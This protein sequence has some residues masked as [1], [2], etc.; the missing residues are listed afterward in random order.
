MQISQ[1]PISIFQKSGREITGLPIQVLPNTA[2]SA[3]KGKSSEAA[4]PSDKVTLSAGVPDR[5]TGVSASALRDKDYLMISAQIFNALPF[6]ERTQGLLETLYFY[7]SRLD[8]TDWDNFTTGVLNA[9]EDFDTF[10]LAA[11]RMFNSSGGSEKQLSEFL[12]F[13]AGLSQQNLDHFLHAADRN[14]G[15]IFDLMKNASVLARD[16]EGMSAYLKAARLSGNA[17]EK[18]NTVLGKF[19]EREQGTAGLGAY[20]LAGIKAG[21]KMVDFFGSTQGMGQ[22]A[23]D[24][25]AAFMDRE[26]SGLNLDYFSTLAASVDNEDQLTAFINRAE[27]MSDKDRA[28]FLKAGAMG[29]DRAGQLMETL[30]RISPRGEDAPSLFLAAAARAES[31]VGILLDR[32]DEIDLGFMATLSLADTVNFLDAAQAAG[33]GMGEVMDTAAKLSGRDKSLFLYAAAQK[34]GNAGELI[35]ALASLSPGEKSEFI[36]KAA[37]K[38]TDTPDD[39]VFMKGI[40]S[41]TAYR[42]FKAAAA[43]LRPSSEG[44]LAQTVM[45]M[46]GD[47]RAGFLNAAAAAGTQ[48]HEFVEQYTQTLS[49]GEQKDFLALAENLSG[50]QKGDLIR[51]MLKAES[52]AGDFIALAGKIKEEDYDGRMFDNFLAAASHT[53]GKQGLA[54]FM[55]Y[56]ASLEKNEKEFFLYI[57]S[58][59]RHA[60]EIASLVEFGRALEKTAWEGRHKLNLDTRSRYHALA[61]QDA[62]AFLDYSQD[63]G[64]RISF[65]KAF[66]DKF[67]KG[68]PAAEK[69]YKDYYYSN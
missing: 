36:L 46:N 43:H 15:Q 22:A 42:D 29:G 28:A 14:P 60:H 47:H 4:V 54:G 9:G 26:T 2:P 12:E 53:K 8:D 57:A 41:D 56:T 67:I 39:T 62:Q 13:S 30:D 69:A 31:R 66:Y 23:R 49:H 25:I 63:I 24:R 20:L 5:S 45:D 16:K 61:R 44:R 50:Q 7:R 40:L 48:V 58:R 27:A 11:N 19:I 34:D 6:N 65:R 17:L 59:Q 3:E 33:P 21:D 55:D 32:I 18:L 52:R 10:I 37:S 51:N 64:P 1:S 35:N 68:D 38:G